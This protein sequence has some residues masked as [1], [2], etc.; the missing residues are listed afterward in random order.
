VKATG[1]LPVGTVTFML[2]DISGSTHLWEQYPESMRQAATRHDELVDALVTTQGGTLVR[3]RGE[4]DSRFAVFTRASDAVRAACGVQRALFAERWQ[5]PEPIRVRIGLHTGET[6]LRDGDYYG[7]TINRCA[8]LRDAC[9]GGQVVMSAV[10]ASLA[11]EHLPERATLRSL[12]RHRLR[13]V[14]EQEEIVQLVHPDLPAEF[15]PLRSMSVAPH[16]LPIQL[17]SFVGRDLELLDLRRL[18]VEGHA[19]LVTLTG[20][21][22]T[23]KT[24]LALQTAEDLL[25]DFPGG[26]FFVQLAPL[27][28]AELLASAI[29]ESIGVREVS[30]QPMLRI[31]TD[32]LQSKTILLVIDNFEHVIQ[33]ASQISALLSGCPLLKMLITS[34]EVLHLSGEHIYAVQPMAVP[35]VTSA[36]SLEDLADFDAVQLFVERAEAVKPNFAL[37]YANAAAVGEICSQLDGLPLAIELAAARVQLLPPE[38]LLERLGR[39]DGQRQTLLTGGGSDRPQRQQALSSAIDWSY[40]LLSPVEQRMFRRIGVFAGG[41]TLDAAESVCGDD[42][43]LKDRVLESVASLIDKSLI[44][45]ADEGPREPRYRML[46]TIREYAL[47]QLQVAG[48]LDETHR[49]MSLFMIDF[50]EAAEPELTGPEQV[51]WLDRIEQE[52]DNIRAALEWCEAHDKTLMLRLSGALWRFWSTRGYVGEGLRSLEAAL[53]DADV[54]SPSLLARALNGAAN[55][56]RELGEYE[57]A[58]QLHQRGLDVCRRQSDIRGTAEALNNLGLVAL[59]QA[60]HELAHQHS[61]AGLELF[62]EVDDV[63]GIAAALNNLGNV[64]RERGRPEEALRLHHESLALRRELGDKRGIALSLNNLANVVLHQGDYWRAAALHQESLAL[65]RQLGDTAAVATSLNNLGNVARVQGDLRAARAHYAESLAVRRELGDKRRVAAALINLGVVEREQGQR[66]RAAELFKESIALRRELGDRPGVQAAL[67][68]LRPLARF[69]LEAAARVFFE[70]LL[71]LRREQEDRAGIVSALT[72]LGEVV[73]DQG[74][75]QAS[76][77]NFEECLALRRSMGDHRGAAATLNLL[78]GLALAAQ[79]HTRAAALLK[80]SLEL[81]TRLGDRR[82]VAADLKNLGMVAAADGDLASAREYY[83]CSLEAYTSTGDRRNVAA[84][85]R[86]LAE[87]P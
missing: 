51:G 87:L 11:R 57:R 17:T 38:A 10:T 18:L 22:G 7:S 56:A 40:G 21:A 81:H 14:P 46:Q 58:R 71:A 77:A 41:F 39:T 53:T 75:L 49:C 28:D 43:Q 78:G 20:A 59:Y 24:R 68:N 84:C 67:D 47:V 70:E 33:Q 83:S 62:R 25:A 42:W 15:P 76:R 32:A 64:A 3:P 86:R 23:G 26:V 45:P 12:G 55:L 9:S 31:V 48:E 6:D 72:S 54:G 63:G 80:Q 65:R 30:G 74:D 37:T 5:M 4:G 85:E 1:D 82:G 36:M 13:D 50:A 8:R 60:Q 73:R 35:G 34:R 16:N 29:G 79:D 19:R 66:D 69:P 61:L 52:H 44:P 27:G 2:T